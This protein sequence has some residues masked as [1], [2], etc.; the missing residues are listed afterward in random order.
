MEMLGLASVLVTSFAGGWIFGRVLRGVIGV[1]KTLVFISLT[2]IIIAWAL[3]I[4]SVNFSVL[5]WYI[6]MV[7]RWA[8][9]K[10]DQ[11]TTSITL[12]ST[13]VSFAVGLLMGLGGI[14]SFGPRET[15]NTYEPD[16]EYIE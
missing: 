9:G 10:V 8:M 16:S 7:T 13:T 5:F 11:I 3:G 15:Y 6:D 12:S 4:V 1:I 14:P 2:P